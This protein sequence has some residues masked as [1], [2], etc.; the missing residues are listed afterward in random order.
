M[1]RGIAFTMSS[2]RSSPDNMF[3]FVTLPLSWQFSFVLVIYYF[4]ALLICLF[5]F[6]LQA[7]YSAMDSGHLVQSPGRHATGDLPGDGGWWANG[8]HT[9]NM[10]HLVRRLQGKIYLLICSPVACESLGRRFGRGPLASLDPSATGHVWT[11]EFMV[12]RLK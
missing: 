1:F 4:I 10:F 11:I 2:L 5:C 3:V 6:K 7:N 12:F 8:I 9:C